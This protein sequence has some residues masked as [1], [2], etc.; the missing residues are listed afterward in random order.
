MNIDCKYPKLNC[1]NINGCESLSSDITSCGS[2]DNNCNIGFENA[3]HLNI[4][5]LNSVVCTY[6]CQDGWEDWDKNLNNGCEFETVICSGPNPNLLVEEYEF[7]HNIN[8][9]VIKTCQHQMINGSLIQIADDCDK[10][11]NNGCEKYLNTNQDCGNCGNI[12]MG[13]QTCGI[14][15]LVSG[16]AY[17]CFTH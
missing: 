2:C 10:N 13:T 6:S 1:D 12:C 5:C 16:A 15:N 4:G 8:Q 11:I 9:C 3:Q 14:K 7:D 17:V